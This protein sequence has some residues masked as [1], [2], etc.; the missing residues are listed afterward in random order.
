MIVI[1][2]LSKKKK[3]ELVFMQKEDDTSCA[4][5]LL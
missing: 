5:C 2:K 1:F 3:L 4:L